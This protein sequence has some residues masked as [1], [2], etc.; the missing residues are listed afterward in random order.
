LKNSAKFLRD[1]HLDDNKSIELIA[2]SS[3]EKYKELQDEIDPILNYFESLAIGVEISIYDLETI[4]LSRKQQIINTFKYSKPY[5][6]KIRE[7]LRNNNLF[8]NL[9]NLSKQLENSL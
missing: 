1:Y 6:D 2:S 4:R 5:I 9:E 7:K 8:V 3:L